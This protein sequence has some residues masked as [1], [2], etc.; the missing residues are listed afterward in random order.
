M[1]ENN[2]TPNPDEVPGQK[3]IV[4]ADQ[5]LLVPAVPTSSKP[6]ALGMCIG[7]GVLLCIVSTALCFVFPPMVVVGLCVAIVSLFFR[8][9][10]GVGLG[11]FLTVGVVLLGMIIYCSIHPLRFD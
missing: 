3:P 7:G 5:I 4:P 10:R 2:P 6:P 1:N 8:G 9:Y 11:Y